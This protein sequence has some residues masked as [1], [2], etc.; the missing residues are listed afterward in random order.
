MM[1]DFT[2]YNT[3]R[4]EFGKGKEKNIG[5]Y[6]K[7]YWLKKVLIV[8]GSERIKENGVFHNVADSLK[9]MELNLQKLEVL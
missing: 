2:F 5:Q 3:T 6:I 4:I 8:Y 7:E 9:K 1:K